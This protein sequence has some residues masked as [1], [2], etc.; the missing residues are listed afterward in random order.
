[1]TCLAACD[2]LE[3]MKLVLA[4]MLMTLS[5]FGADV[6]GKWKGT[7]EVAGNGPVE[8]TF[9]FKVDGTKLTGE[10]ESQL[11]GKSEIQNGKVEGDNITFTIKANIQENEMTMNYKGKVEGDK[12]TLAT[13][14]EGVG[15]IEWKLTKQ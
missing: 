13:E 1:M 11:A 15:A 14:I 2:T 8:R 7:A 5:V 9:S 3:G 12:I 4:F 10:T 6:S